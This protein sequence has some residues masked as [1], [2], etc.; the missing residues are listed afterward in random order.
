MFACQSAQV[1]VV[2]LMLKKADDPNRLASLINKKN[3]SA[4]VLR[5]NKLNLFDRI[6][7]LP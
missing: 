2:D 4:L 5:R 6:I 7:V 1:E 3:L